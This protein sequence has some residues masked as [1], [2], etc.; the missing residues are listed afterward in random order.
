MQRTPR[1]NY[2][3]LDDVPKLQCLLP[4]LKKKGFCCCFL[5]A[6]ANRNALPEH[7]LLLRNSNSD[8]SY[9]GSERMRLSL[10]TVK[11]WWSAETHALSAKHFSSEGR[12]LKD[13][14]PIRIRGIWLTE[15]INKNLPSSPPVS[16]HLKTN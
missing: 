13:A 15:K 1:T 4:I 3:S 12:S 14:T 10:I 8:H 11:Q 2:H 16:E 7:S 6:P 5:S 9:V